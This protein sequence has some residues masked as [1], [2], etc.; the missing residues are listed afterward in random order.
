MLVRSKPYAALILSMRAGQE[1][2]EARAL[3]DG[4][5]LRAYPPYWACGR[6]WKR[7][8]GRVTDQGK[9]SVK[10]LGRGVHETRVCRS[11]AFNL[12][13][14]GESSTLRV[15]FSGRSNKYLF[16]KPRKNTI[17]GVCPRALNA[18]VILVFQL[19]FHIWLLLWRNT[20][21]AQ[22]WCHKLRKQSHT[23]MG[24]SGRKWGMIRHS[25]PE[26]FGQFRNRSFLNGWKGDQW[27][28]TLNKPKTKL[29]YLRTLQM[30]PEK[31]LIQLN[32]TINFY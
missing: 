15:H 6:F 20:N 13:V 27:M 12:V 1:D 10:A 9:D 16:K 19:C 32:R 17:P 5:P 4:G 30:K 26:L 11:S 8:T 21:R 7:R 28:L 29:T 24:V 22:I 3:G 31:S 2:Q 23:Y 18:S 14:G 25:Q